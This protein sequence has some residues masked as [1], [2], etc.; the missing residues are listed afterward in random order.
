MLLQQAAGT[1][2]SA[3]LISSNGHKHKSPLFKKK[4]LEYPS[5]FTNHLIY[6]KQWALH[7]FSEPRRQSERQAQQLRA[8]KKC[9]PSADAWSLRLLVGTHKD[10]NCWL[11]KVIAQVHTSAGVP[12]TET[13]RWQLVA[14]PLVYPKWISI[15]TACQ[16]MLSCKQLKNPPSAA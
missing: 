15:G 13:Q 1:S 11:R 10:Q 5:L 6:Q 4:R 16:V 14:S 12:L 9:R 3:E 8:R 2:M 7:L